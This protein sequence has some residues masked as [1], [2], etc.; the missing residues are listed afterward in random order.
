MENDKRMQSYC[1]IHEQGH[2]D[3]GEVITD[4][5]EHQ[6]TNKQRNLLLASLHAF[7]KLEINKF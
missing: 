5:H 6:I 2:K 1:L 7:C 4:W 3:W